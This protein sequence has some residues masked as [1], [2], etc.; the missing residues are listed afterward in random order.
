MVTFSTSLASVK[1]THRSPMDST[2]KGQ[3]RGALMFS[4]ISVFDV[5][6]DRRLNERSSKQLR[7]R[8][9]QTISHWLWRQCNGNVCLVDPLSVTQIQVHNSSFSK[10]ILLAGK[11]IPKAIIQYQRNVKEIY[12]EVRCLHHFNFCFQNTSRANSWQC[13]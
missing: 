4:S 9:F 5:F 8:W 12:K 13:S 6:F 2:H 10:T 11:I 7:R 3:S 1:E